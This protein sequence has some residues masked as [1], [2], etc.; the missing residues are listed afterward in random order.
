MNA[1]AN[2]MTD[3]AYA[4]LLALRNH[5]QDARECIEMAIDSLMEEYQCS[6][7]RAAIVAMQAWTDLEDK[8]RPV[9]YVDVSL[10]TGNMVVIHDADG[11][12]SIFSARE[13]LQLRELNNNPTR[14]HA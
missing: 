14:I 4:Q 11:R 9:A 7:R 8:G 2:S 10:T 13:L 1:V 12:T 5:S 6:R 3:A